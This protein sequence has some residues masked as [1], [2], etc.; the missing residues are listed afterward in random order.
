MSN[1]KINTHMKKKLL[2]I[3]LLFLFCYQVKAQNPANGKVVLQAFWKDYWN[4]NYDN[5]WFNYLAEMAPRLKLLGINA[6]W[7]PPAVKNSSIAD[8]GYSPFDNYDLGDKIQKGGATDPNIA[9]HLKIR[10]GDK[11]EHLRMIAI[12]HANGIEV[13]EDI[14]LSHYSNA[15][16]LT[17]GGGRDQ[18]AMDD[19]K[20]D[21]YKT[22]RYVCYETP[23]DDTSATNYKNRKGRFSKNWQNFHPNA[24]HNEYT[25]DLTRPD[26]G[27]SA[28]Y[29]GG[30]G[31]SGNAIYNPAQNPTYMV[32]QTR[33]WLLWYKKQT[34]FDGVRLDAVK[35][36]SAAAMEDFLWNLQNSAGFANGTADMYAAGEFLDGNPNAGSST[37]LW[38]QSVK[39]RAGTFDYALRYGIKDMVNQT[40]GSYDLSL[41]A[42]KLQYN[43]NKIATFVNNFDTFRPFYSTTNPT[44]GNYQGWDVANETGAGHIE[45]NNPRLDASYAI[46]MAVDGSPTIWIEDLFNI[47]YTGKRYTHIPSNTTD[48]PVWD[49]IANLI[50]CHNKLNFKAGAMKWRW[51]GAD[52]LVIERS[53]KAIIGINDNTNQWQSN[54]VNTDF[55]NGT[56]LM[57]FGGSSP[58]SDLRTVVN[59]QVNIST[60]PVD[61]TAKRKGYSV[62]APSNLQTAFNADFSP[63]PKFTTQQ[64]ELSNDLGDSQKNSLQQ[65]GS[66]P[67]NSTAFRTA[68]KILIDAG[69]PVT[70]T[71]TPTDSSQSLTLISSICGGTYNTDSISGKGTLSFTY[72]PNSIQYITLKARNTYGNNSGQSGVLITARYAAPPV[73]K[74]ASYP[75]KDA[76]IYTGI[77]EY[78]NSTFQ[79]Y[80][81][82][83]AGLFNYDINNLTETSLKVYDLL[84]HEVYQEQLNISDGHTRTLNLLHLQKGI[85][86]I[87]LSVDNLPLMK[88]IILY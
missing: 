53:G 19:F 2:S 52:H 50:R 82:P 13:I 5:S 65:G 24:Q 43:R 70:V 60:P 79:I 28:C 34:G 9:H 15:G 21:K 22:F 46:A 47:G 63:T 75:S 73:A 87:Q 78:R 38:I 12:M 85:Y 67:S 25:T 37:D 77:E 41:I 88:K 7:I 8:N 59:G 11:N 49:D 69:K 23:E 74:M 66:I 51:Q 36:F 55:P 27:P 35:H 84:G 18:T 1:K 31:L 20:T 83:G 48:L 64:W 6:I 4:S 61:G 76:C 32:D 80:P 39:G 54:T 72:T 56:I 42:G 57:D 58:A 62:W 81:N 45:P 86:F 17:G 16:N 29:D 68:G 26:F 44:S 3:C 30:Y 71:L 14:V 10:S 33:K 40:G